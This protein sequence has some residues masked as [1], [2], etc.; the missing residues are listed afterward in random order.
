[1][2]NVILT[3]HCA[4]VT[5]DSMNHMSRDVARGLIEVFSGQKPTWPVVWPEEK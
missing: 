5:L 3:P 1:M 2:D 4:G